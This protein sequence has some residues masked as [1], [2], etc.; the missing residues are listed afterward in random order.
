MKKF[1]VKEIWSWRNLRLKKFDLK[2]WNLKIRNL[3]I[4]N[5]KIHNLK[6]WNLIFGIG[7]FGIEKLGICKFRVWKFGV[8]K[9]RIEYWQLNRKWK[10]SLRTSISCKLSFCFT[11][12]QRINAYEPFFGYLWAI[13]WSL[14]VTISIFNTY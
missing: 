7:K 8:C 4:R 3:K 1:E 12:N 6:I 2:I 11:Q 13:F 9:F 5:L 10:S 14:W